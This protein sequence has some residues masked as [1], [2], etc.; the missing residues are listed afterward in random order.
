MHPDLLSM[1]ILGPYLLNL[2]II[3]LSGILRLL[4]P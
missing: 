2:M 3:Y 4:L 1:E